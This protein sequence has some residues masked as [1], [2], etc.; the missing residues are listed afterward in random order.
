MFNRLFT[1]LLHL[2]PFELVLYALSWIYSK[3]FF[4][5]SAH[6]LFPFTIR[7][8]RS[9][10]LKGSL[11]AKSNFYVEPFTGSK[12]VFGANVVFNRNCY[13][14]SISSINIGD[15][16]L[17]GPNVFISDHDHGR[18]PLPLSQ[19]YFSQPPL[20]RELSS[21]PIS[22]GS[23]VWV[24]ANVCI[25]KGVIIGD[26]CVVGANSVVTKSLP[27]NSICAGVPCKV[28]RTIDLSS[29]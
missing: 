22:V 27:P 12:I 11:F 13:L 9:I 29:C 14:T 2:G 3:I 26:N 15:N 24:G 10:V 8:H 6:I 28:I 21:S 19:E 23:S 1:R 18:Y 17:F 4:N 7:N 20:Q 16:C 5:T 25:L